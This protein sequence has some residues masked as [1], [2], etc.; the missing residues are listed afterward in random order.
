MDLNVGVLFKKNKKKSDANMKKLEEFSVKMN[1][2]PPTYK[3]MI[4][5]GTE[6]EKKLVV[7]CSWGSFQQVGAG[8][9]TELAQEAAATNL[10]N[11]LYYMY[12]YEHRT[13]KYPKNKNQV[14]DNRQKAETTYLSPSSESSENSND[15][16]VQEDVLPI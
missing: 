5:E 8:K 1:W 2:Q 4:E 13:S 14:C 12:E 6:H 9:S 7:K 3:V 11:L 16:I 15:V 10:I